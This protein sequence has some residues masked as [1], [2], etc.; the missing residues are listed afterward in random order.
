MSN[1]NPQEKPVEQEQQ[2][3]TTKAV[4]SSFAKSFFSPVEGGSPK[5]RLNAED[6]GRLLRNGLIYGLGTAAVYILT[7][8]SGMDF[9]VYTPL[10]IG[11][12]AGLIDALRKALR[13]NK[14]EL[15]QE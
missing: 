12:C 13:D 7:Q 8:V 3:S 9:G 5:G 4:A 6:V 11:L 10:I 14:I 15:E 1:N 2:V